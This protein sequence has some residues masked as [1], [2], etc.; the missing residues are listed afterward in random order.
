MIGT[1]LRAAPAAALAVLVGWAFLDGLGV[2]DPRWRTP[3]LALLAIGLG[4]IAIAGAF[5]WAW[6]HPIGLTVLGGSYVGA[7]AFVLG[8]QVLP[9]LVYLVLGIVH[10]ELR[11]LA[12][13][14]A[15]IYDAPLG[16]AERT[17]IRGALV[18]ALLRLSVASVLGGL[19][20]VL[21]A[22]LAVAGIVP[23]TTIPTAIL[24]AAALV[25]VVVLIALLPILER[26]AT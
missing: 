20:P 18:R 17:R 7:H 9:A 11:V 8:I 23:A 15:P 13:R 19:V 5:G 24:L 4:L 3:L 6:V 22:D 10:V 21:A 16:P 14:F 12:E 1:A 25:A 26:R 2:A